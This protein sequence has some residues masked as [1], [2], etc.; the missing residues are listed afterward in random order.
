MRTDTLDDLC[1]ELAEL[2]KKFVTD[3]RHS[4]SAA[5]LRGLH[6]QKFCHLAADTIKKANERIR[7][8]HCP[9]RAE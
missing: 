5:E 1:H 3:P 8:C 4:L 9:R 6:F 7:G 2:R